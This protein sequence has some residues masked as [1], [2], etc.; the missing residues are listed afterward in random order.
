MNVCIVC[1]IV[2]TLDFSSYVR[3]AYTTF[4]YYD[5]YT[6]RLIVCYMMCKLLYEYVCICI[7]DLYVYCLLCVCVCGLLLTVVVD[8]RIVYMFYIVRKS[9]GIKFCLLFVLN[10]PLRSGSPPA[11]L[12]SN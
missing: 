4:M 7:L 5:M 2:Y 11:K 8:F 6:I 3:R 12:N 1:N 9:V 10:R